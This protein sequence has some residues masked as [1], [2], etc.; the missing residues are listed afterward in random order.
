MNHH[1]TTLSIASLLIVAAIPTSATRTTTSRTFP[2]PPPF[3]QSEKLDYHPNFTVT[4]ISGP[5]VVCDRQQAD[6]DPLNGCKLAPGRN[7]DELMTII[8]RAIR[9]EQTQHQKDKEEWE[10]ERQ[11]LLQRLDPHPAP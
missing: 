7:L 8:I 6:T 2:A 10:I 3:T 11:E 5:L 9:V 4:D 1:L